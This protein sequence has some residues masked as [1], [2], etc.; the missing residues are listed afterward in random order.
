MMTKYVL[1]IVSTQWGFLT[2]LTW[3]TLT[4]NPEKPLP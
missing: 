4:P 3:Q 2:R 1:P